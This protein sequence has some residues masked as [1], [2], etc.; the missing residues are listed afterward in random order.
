MAATETTIV[1]VYDSTRWSSP[2]YD[3]S[4]GFLEDGTTV[5]GAAEGGELT[6]G[7]TYEFYGKW[8][9]HSEFGKQFKFTMFTVKA[10]HSRTG[11]VAYLERYATGIGPAIAS[12]LFDAFG[13]DAVKVLRTQPEA[14]LAIPEI[15]RFLTP[16][17]AQAAAAQLQAIAALEDTKIE[18]TN[19]FA[20]RGFPD[21][22]I[23]ECIAKWR[24][25]APARVKRDPFC[26]LVEEMP[27]CGFARCDHLYLDLCLNPERV[28]R[29]VICLWHILHSDSS[30]HTW[31][32]AEI[33]QRRL[34]EAV[35]VSGS[36][37]VVE[38]KLRKA[39]LVGCRSKWLARRRDSDGK[40]WLA[41][42]ERARQ[43]EYLAERL[44]ELIYGQR[45]SATTNCLPAI[46]TRCA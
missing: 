38:V 37:G 40:L 31:I 8:T 22:L 26:L 19:L 25:Q 28:K 34:G 29:Q 14:V 1:G 43:E 35:S 16:A 46:T 6:P 42:G 15:R 39:I 41:E 10:P 45:K 23:D 12:R 13:T 21:K 4:I 36:I 7:I 27:G 18:L 3:Y 44:K 2:E 20:G 32:P 5:C 17:K 33:A 9:E 11:I 24:I 30:G